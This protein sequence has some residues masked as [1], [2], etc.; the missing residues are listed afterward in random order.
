MIKIGGNIDIVNFK[1]IIYVTIIYGRV[2]TMNLMEIMW[3]K[4][5]YICRCQMIRHTNKIK[6]SKIHASELLN[7]GANTDNYINL[8]NIL[9]RINIINEVNTKC[10]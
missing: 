9:A 10:F 1:A 6:C 5:S 7:V 8:G 2:S 3:W 4:Q